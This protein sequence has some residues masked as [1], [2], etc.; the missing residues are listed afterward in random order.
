MIDDF[1]N[2]KYTRWYFQIVDRRTTNIPNADVYCEDHH[3]VPESFFKNRSRPGP[4]GWLD[5]DPEDS[6]NKVMLTA[7]EHFICHWLLTKMTTDV[8]LIKMQDALEMMNVD[9]ENQKRYR[10][11]I[12]SRVFE[13]NRIKVARERSER[14]KGEGNPMNNPESRELMRQLK[15]GVKREKFSDKWLANLAATRQGER[16]GMYGK[17][18][19]DRTKELMRKLATGR[20]QSEEHKKKKADAVRGSK[21][22]KKVCPHCS[23]ACAVNTYPRFH[24]DN[25]KMKT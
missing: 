1:S 22:E 23:Y 9:S 25:C 3:I 8:A 21:R 7:R 14:M 6:L 20:V 24:G 11:L 5:G 2:N 17:N 13:R 15:T 18:H 10:T 19:S 12:T 4:P 16:N